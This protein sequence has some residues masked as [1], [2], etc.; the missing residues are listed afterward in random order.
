MKV[1]QTLC[2]HIGAPS[3]HRSGH[4]RGTVRAPSGHRRGIAGIRFGSQK[5]MY[6]MCTWQMTHTHALVHARSR[7]CTHTHMRTRT[8]EHIAEQHTRAARMHAIS[9][10]CTQRICRMYRMHMHVENTAGIHVHTGTPTHIVSRA[11][12]YTR[13]LHRPA[14]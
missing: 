4:R 1:N 7:I 12:S 9:Q 10:S 14:L 5:N 2:F 3:G 11:H 6:S 13:A 8:Q